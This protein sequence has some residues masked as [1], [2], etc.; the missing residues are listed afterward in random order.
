MSTSHKGVDVAIVGA[1]GI[2][3]EAV[4][5]L[6]QQRQFPVNNL[7]LLASERSAGTKLAF[8]GKSLSVKLLDEFDFHQVQIAIFVATDQVSAD[9]IPQAVRAGCIVLDN[10]QYY[11]NDPDVPLVIPGVNIDA[12]DKINRQGTV[13]ANPDSVVI[14]LWTVLKPIYDLARIVRINVAT[15]QAVSG[16]G[17]RAIKELAVQTASVLNGRGAKASFYKKQITFNVFPAI[18]E[19]VEQGYSSAEWQFIQQSKK[20]I[21]DAQLQLSVTC[22]QVPVFYADS[23]VVN[24]E[25]ESPVNAQEIAKLLKKN[26]EINVLD[27]FESGVYATPATDATSADTVFVSRI[28][29]DLHHDCGLNMWIVGDNVRKGAALNTVQ[30]AE[31]LIKSHL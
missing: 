16:Q 7:Y 13:I 26:N 30:I 21:D 1:T 23:M 10:S 20:I 29:N 15:Y 6:L 9:Y 2:V 24:I 5:E 19:L 4:L 8:N 25:T 27:D 3:G 18:G 14:Q 28:R 17:K 12:L 11:T 22:V 31:N